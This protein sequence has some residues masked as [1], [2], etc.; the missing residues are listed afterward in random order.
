MEALYSRDND[1]RH[2]GSWQ[3]NDRAEL[4]A[5][6]LSLRSQMFASITLLSCLRLSPAVW[7][8]QRVTALYVL[9]IMHVRLGPCM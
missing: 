9:H 1:S 6:K 8:M 4:M 2:E 5:S 3:S 7:S